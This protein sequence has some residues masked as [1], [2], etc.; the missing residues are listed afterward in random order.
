MTSALAPPWSGPFS[1]AIAATMAECMSVSVAA[2]TRAAKVE[3]LSSWSACRISATSKARVAT[4]LG[5]SP[6][7]MYRK[8]AA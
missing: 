6:V 3:A 7:S 4:A 8:F 5:R 2:A 1:V